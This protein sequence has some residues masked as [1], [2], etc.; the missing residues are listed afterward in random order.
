MSKTVSVLGSAMM[1]NINMLRAASDL[2][3]SAMTNDINMLR[4]AIF[5]WVGYDDQYL[6]VKVCEVPLDR[7]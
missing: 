6:H 7:L 2:Y 3:G 1:I 4:A 5:L